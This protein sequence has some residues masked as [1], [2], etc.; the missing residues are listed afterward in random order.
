[1]TDADSGINRQR[2]AF[3]LARI[4]DILSWEKSKEQEKDV[5]FIELGEY[6]CEVRARQH[7]ERNSSRQCPQESNFTILSIGG[8]SQASEFEL[9]HGE[10]SILALTEN[11][12]EL[13]AAARQIVS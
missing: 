2:A 9:D 4:D 8:F 3:V 6:L 13:S 5:R 10:V 12:G 11:F 7:S 1:M